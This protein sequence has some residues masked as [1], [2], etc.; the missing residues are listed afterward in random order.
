MNP[1]L[2]DWFELRASL[3]AA[4]AVAAAALGR[5]ESRGAHQ[6]TDF[7]QRDPAQT[8][9]RTVARDASGTL[10]VGGVR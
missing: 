2:I 4:Q 5:T 9:S 1:T 8:G 3:L 7:P 10:A 6:R